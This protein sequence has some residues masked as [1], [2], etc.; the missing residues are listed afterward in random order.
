MLI[1]FL[2]VSELPIFMKNLYFIQDRDQTG[3]GWAEPL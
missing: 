3:T 1:I 2:I